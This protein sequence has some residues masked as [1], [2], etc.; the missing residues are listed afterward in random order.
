[1]RYKQFKVNL[2]EAL[3][4]EV[5]MSPR[6][7]QDFLN[8]DLSKGMLMGFELEA[9]IHNVRNYDEGESEPD[10][11]YD[12]RVY[13]IENIISFFGR[14]DDPNG[15]ETLKKLQNNIYDDFMSWQDA[16]FDEYLQTEE[17]QVTLKEFIRDY[18]EDK[19]YN[20]RQ[21]KLAFNAAEEGKPSDVYAEAEMS[22]QEKLRDEWQ[23][24]GNSDF[25]KYS[26]VMD[27]RYMSDVY[28][29][30]DNFLYW[31]YTGYSD[32]QD[33]INV[34]YVADEFTLKTGLKAEGYQDYHSGSRRS[35]QAE[36][37]WIIEPDS[38]IDCDGSED[39]GLEF[40]SPALPIERAITEMKAAFNF[41]Q[42]YGYTNSSTGLHVNI[43]VP[44]LTNDNL[45]YV[46]LALFLGDKHILREFDRLTNRFCESAYNKVAYKVGQLKPEEIKVV[47]DKMREGLNLAASKL[48]H[49]GIT[50][51]YTS[52]NTKDGYVEFRGPG[53]DY[54]SKDPFG[55]GNTALR[56]ALCL[57][58]ASDEKLYQKEYA[59][60]LTKLLNDVGEKDDLTK[61]KDYISQY[62]A[63][64]PERRKYVLQTI[65]AEQ[66]GRAERKNKKPGDR[67]PQWMVVRRD[68][69]TGGGMAVHAPTAID[70]VK[71]VAKG[72]DMNPVDLEAIHW[73]KWIEIRNAEM[74]KEN[75]PE[76]V[77]TI[78]PAKW[79]TMMVGDPPPPRTVRADNEANAIDRAK[80]MFGDEFKVPHD[81]ISVI[82]N[83]EVGERFIFTIYDALGQVVNTVRGTSAE[84]AVKQYGTDY[85]VD[86]TGY[87]AKLTSAP[88]DDHIG[89]N[90]YLV[91][92][93]NSYKYWIK[94]DSAAE[95][96]TKAG[97]I[98]K[99]DPLDTTVVTIQTS[100]GMEHSMTGSTEMGQEE[101]GWIIKDPVRDGLA[102]ATV[103]ARTSDE[104]LRIYYSTH[105]ISTSNNYVA[106]PEQE[107]TARNF[108]ITNSNRSFERVLNNVD[109][110]D[111]TEQ[112]RK[113]ERE[114]GLTPNSLTVR[115]IPE[116]GE[117]SNYED[118]L[119]AAQAINQ[120]NDPDAPELPQAH[121]SWIREIRY[122]TD[123]QLLNV[124]Q[125]LAVTDRLNEQ[126]VAYMRGK[127]K[128]ELTRRGIDANAQ[129]NKKKWR[130]DL[131]V[132]D[133]NYTR[134]TEVFANN[135]QEAKQLASEE[136]GSVDH[137]YLT[138]TQKS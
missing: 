55:I 78:V 74:A 15:D 116:R 129:Q 105:D 30:Y 104:A 135:E 87:S 69:T 38:S 112:A 72:W 68:S 28:Y 73:D 133:S 43:S 92:L 89:K 101:R 136:F 49:S 4:S 53:G 75:L 36:E 63:A 90:A 111:A 16:E 44:G 119:R 125:N 66:Q 59:S 117:Y 31:P 96:R 70:A 35:A 95:A 128:E 58:I 60:R 115:P 3:L 21:M 54:L 51:K 25:D 48:I 122:K 110:E 2:A 121:K 124:Y 56:M 32:G 88:R 26:D 137:S 76:W 41:I 62:Q 109:L 1:M 100:G 79:R 40:I 80:E 102:V 37:R 50:N 77:L 12:E 34:D 132:P 126:Q 107:P 6:A 120:Q 130:V 106:V 39:G 7:F 24:E 71:D 83:H 93:P 91:Q 94:A 42:D 52:I 114:E 46:K 85:G 14:G 29:K 123:T 17:A 81:W 127:I 97:R 134:T 11:D 5:E 23:D 84:D 138:A 22:A 61:F 45:D 108:Q 103:Q 86:T 18:L 98:Y 47:M 82:P 8:S 27:M 65:K 9:C 118:A 99:V 10:M 113:W 20:E 67:N 64:S 33:Y 19:D 57:R 13:D 131:K